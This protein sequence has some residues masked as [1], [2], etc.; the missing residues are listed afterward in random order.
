MASKNTSADT[1]KSPSVKILVG[2]HKPAVLFKNEVLVPIH[3][4]RALATQTSKDGAM[5]DTDYQWMLDNMI[6]DDTGDNISL[7]NRELNEL[8]ALY[9]AWKN[10]D[11]LGNPDYIGFMH[12]RRHLCFDGT[13]AART[14]P[15]G[16]I[17]VSK[18]DE[19]YFKNFHLFENQIKQSIKGYD[20]VIGEKCDVRKLGSANPYDHYIRQQYQKDYQT[21]MDILQELY[22]DYAQAAAEYNQS[23]YAYFANIFVCKKEQFMAYMQWLYPLIQRLQKEIDISTYNMQQSRVVAYLSEWLMGIYYTHL[24]KQK[25]IK[26]NELKRSFLEQADLTQEAQIYPVFEHQKTAICLACDPNYL[27][28]GGVM[29]QSIFSHVDPKKYYDICILMEHITTKARQMLAAMPLPPNISV[30]L[31]DIS[32]LTQSKKQYFFTSA[33]IAA[34]TYYRFFI[35]QIFSSYHKVLYLDVDMV[36]LTDISPLMEMNLHNHLLA[37]AR[38]P[39][40]YR[41]MK[42]NPADSDSYYR[43]ILGLKNPFNY[44][45]AGVLLFNI[46]QMIRQQTQEALFATLSRV[47]NPRLW[48]QD[49]LNAVCE[50][51]VLFLDLKWNVEYHLPIVAPNYLNELPRFIRQDYI[52]AYNAPFI[53]HYS[54]CWKPWEDPSLP[55]AHHFWEYAKQTPFYEELLLKS[56]QTAISHTQALILHRRSILYKY[57]RC[58]ILSKIT[59]GNKRKH[60][61]Q[62]RDNLHTLVRR[63]R[64]T[65]PPLYFGNLISWGLLALLTPFL[66]RITAVLF[67]C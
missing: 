43:N 12:Y 23:P 19:S 66:N 33:H 64:S 11:K 4:G 56:Y 67:F 50:G 35:P 6:G 34:S 37:A 7:Q 52:N 48:D 1:K 2:Y 9:W 60:Y 8:T 57:Y 31:I 46:P 40:V 38:D 27:L 30:R 17:H 54:G 3:L 10:Y 59:W 49:I 20:W 47:G 28:T 42:N 55:L 21:A 5:S 39:E 63:L 25:N 36:A 13:N 41:A 26:T 15:D 62:K 14:S 44:F 22:P 53:L 18:L 45:Q 24:K 61:K 58:K 65:L 32:P 51:Q 16:Q 29:L